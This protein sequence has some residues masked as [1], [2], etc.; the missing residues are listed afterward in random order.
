MRYVRKTASRSKYQFSTAYLLRQLR[1]FFAKH[2]RSPT[3]QDY[4]KGS[5]PNRKHYIRHFGSSNNGLRRANLPINKVAKYG[6]DELLH[7][8]RS[9][10]NQHGHS[11]SAE[12]F[13]KG[14][15][16]PSSQAILDAFGSWNKALAIA[17][18]PINRPLRY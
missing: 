5:L 15:D 9:F 13:D 16:C 3:Y 14:K 1:G 11:P 12:D 18:L 7:T 4:G 10:F 17:G 6:A 2:R 8:I